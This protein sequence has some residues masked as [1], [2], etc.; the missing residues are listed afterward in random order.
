M[1][2][3]ALSVCVAVSLALSAR[4]QEDQPPWMQEGH[5]SRL[6]VMAMHTYIQAHDD[7]LP[8]DMGAMVPYLTGDLTKATPKDKAD[9]FRKTLLSHQDQGIKIPDD[10]DES[11]AAEHSSFAYLAG[12]G[13]KLGDL[14]DWNNLAVMH[15]KLDKGWA[16]PR[17][18]GN[19]GDVTV[20]VG[21]VDSHV[22][23]MPRARA[24]QVIAESTAVFEALRTGKPLP[25]AHQVVMDLRIVM[26]A[27]HAYAKAHEGVL[28]PDLG[29]T[30]EFV[31]KDSKRLTTAADRAK[32]FL[33]PSAKATTHVP[34]EPTAEWVN[35]RTSWVYLARQGP[36]DTKPVKLG[37]IED[38]FNTI[39]V[40]GKLDSPV[41]FMRGGA[42][43]PL[44]KAGRGAEIMD[45]EYAAWIAGVSKRVVDSARSGTALP[46]H[47]NAYRDVRLILGG[48]MAYAK[49]HRGKIPGDLGSALPY[50]L[51]DASVK[52]RALVF[53][54]PARERG[55]EIPEALT[56]E[57]VNAHCTYV[58][59]PKGS[60]DLPLAREAGVQLLIHGPIGE[61]YEVMFP[62]MKAQAVPMG[63][64]HGDIWMSPV[65]SIER[66][67]NESATTLKDLY[68]ATKDQK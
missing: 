39:L 6:I 42:G 4:A 38:P 67:A 52:E 36:E 31:P 5:R 49:E 17:A 68:A 2:T 65:E 14:A 9:A 33:A 44:G 26:E 55:A 22:E 46:D 34:E 15:L 53:L 60:V 28:P 8:P 10:A 32:V 56:A 3:F 24:E 48:V 21:F 57:W 29:A 45:V 66:M 23:V 64:V 1:R 50:V 58:Y 35:E 25:D 54:S 16:S 30:L 37:E 51:P 20:A 12:G 18:D 63:L 59:L 62:G 47:L 43:I 40:H 11:W 61:T 19:P 27:V 7:Q 41:P 13:I